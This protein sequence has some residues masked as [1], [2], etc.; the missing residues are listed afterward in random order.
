[1]SIKKSKRARLMDRTS[2]KK[3]SCL[4]LVETGLLWGTPWG[5]KPQLSWPPGSYEHYS[6]FE[7]RQVSDNQRE[8]LDWRKDVN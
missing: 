8:S 4:A 1:M 7:M 2:R 3:L 5:W 6:P